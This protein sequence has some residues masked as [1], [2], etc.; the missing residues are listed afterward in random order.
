[1]RH[2]KPVYNVGPNEVGVALLSDFSKWFYFC[3]FSEVVH[4]NDGKLVSFLGS[5]QVPYY[6]DALYRERPRTQDGC[7]ELRGNPMHWSIPLSLLTSPWVFHSV[8]FQSWLIVTLS[9]DFKC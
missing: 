7:E 1:M 5:M 9:K 6:F 4:S 3:P 8:S 2:S